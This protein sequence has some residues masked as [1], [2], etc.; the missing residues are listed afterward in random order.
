MKYYNKKKSLCN[1]P[2]QGEGVGDL[3]FKYKDGTP[4]P[5]ILLLG[6]IF[7]LILLSGCIS[8]KEAITEYYW[9]LPPEKPRF[10]F[11]GIVADES[12]FKPSKSE[13][14]L[15]L[16]AGKSKVRALMRPFG[17]AVDS[18]GNIFV[19]DTNLKYVVVFDV[20]KKKIRRIGDNGIYKL[21]TPIDIVILEN[22][23]VLV[24]DSFLKKIFLYD[25]EGNLL[26]T[27]GTEKQFISPTG[28]AYEPNLKRIYIADTNKHTIIVL[29]MNGNTLFTIGERGGD[30]GKF[31]FPTD[32]TLSDDKL[33]VVDTFNGRVQIFDLE[34]RFLKMFGEFGTTPG[35]FS[36]PKGIAVDAQKNIYVTDAAFDNFQIFN[37]DGETLM[38][39]GSTG[40]G[41]GEFQLTAG[42][43]IDKNN[44][45][46][47][48]DQLNS[49]VQVFQFL[50]NNR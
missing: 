16:L 46:Y 9:P 34:G 22:D 2:C 11:I 1:S 20:V 41:P 25:N 15:M 18:K 32:I 27:Y 42:I 37:P 38:F 4:I 47:V 29:D 24:S 48:V 6:M 31:N 43:C 33:Y 44:F 8:T 45:V 10:K 17:V 23:N 26:R 28:L 7:L 50:S 19:T 21:H 36:R 40:L 49:R 14:L 39:I 35:H 3:R 5:L 30:P 13:K 12:Y